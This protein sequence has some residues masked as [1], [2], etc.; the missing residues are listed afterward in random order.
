MVWQQR[1]LVN[2]ED[3]GKEIKVVQ[4]K[5]WICGIRIFILRPSITWSFVSLSYFG[6]RIS[7]E[8]FIFDVGGS[9]VYPSKSM[10]IVFTG[11]MC[12]IVV[13]KFMRI[14][15]PTLNFQVGNVSALPILKREINQI[16]T[17]IDLIVEEAVQIARDDWDSQETS[18][19][20]R[21]PVIIDSSESSRIS[22]A[23]EETCKY[24]GL[25]RTRMKTLE[26]D[27]NRLFIGAY[28]LQDELSPKSP[29]TRSPSTAQTVRRTSSVCFPTP[30][31]A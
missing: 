23:Y 21:L 27:N 11:F 19:S 16:Q 1:I 3:D 10:M 18:W 31:A 12:S 17:Q 29:M 26:E 2:W 5:S 14:L 28:G 4:A 22:D 8:G 9:C 6:V 15:N 30:S 13:F 20:F 7:D 25:S 24:Y